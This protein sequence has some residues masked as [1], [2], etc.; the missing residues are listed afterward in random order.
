MLRRLQCVRLTLGSPRLYQ[1]SRVMGLRAYATQDDGDTEAHSRN[2]DYYALLLDQPISSSAP[3]PTPVSAKGTPPSLS[4]PII[5]SKPSDGP[6]ARERG[7]S[8]GEQ[9][10]SKPEEPDNCCMSGCVNCVW[11]TYREEMEQWVQGQR[12]REALMHTGE[13]RTR[14]QPS[15]PSDVSASDENGMGNHGSY[16]GADTEVD[17]ELFQS[18]P[19]GIREFM[20]QEKRLR[21]K[22]ER[23]NGQSA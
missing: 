8:R 16:P 17:D 5:F 11:D 21:E 23:N 13:D 14:T 2:D 22:R 10:L 20:K 6:S 12:K 7:Y 18:V 15:A 3:T 4:Q 1:L 19:I 9:S